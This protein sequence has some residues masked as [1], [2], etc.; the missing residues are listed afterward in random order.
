MK[1]CLMTLSD[2]ILLKKISVK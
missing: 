2:K 1:N